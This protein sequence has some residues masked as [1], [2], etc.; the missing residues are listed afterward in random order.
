MIIVRLMGGLGN[1]LFQY[2]LGRKLSCESGAELKL[3]TSHFTPGARKYRL[4]RFNVVE[5][6]A[7]PL[8]IG[9]L[10][11]RARKGIV[12]KLELAIKVR[13]GMQK[14]SLVKENGCGFD[15]RALRRINEVYLDGYWQCERYFEDIKEVLMNEFALKTQPDTPNRLIMEQMEQTESVSIHIRRGDYVSNPTFFKVHGVC[16][17]HYYESAVRLITEKIKNPHF[18]MF[19]D[20]LAWC[21]QNLNLGFPVTYVDCNGEER[22]Y[23]DLRLMSHCKNHIVANSSF[24]WWGAWL[25]INPQRMVIAPKRWFADEAKDDRDIV[26]RDWMRI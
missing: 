6:I 7:T 12:G 15:A 1:Q 3:D 17:T 26:P 14:P 23:E 22:D 19:S 9:R 5:N 24:S 4:D 18:F 16:S 11:G 10:S 8:E 2:A 20:D 21:R 25:G 13:L